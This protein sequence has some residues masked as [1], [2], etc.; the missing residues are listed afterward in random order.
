MA[1]GLTLVAVAMVS[2]PKVVVVEGSHPSARPRPVVRPP[3]SHQLSFDA[4][5]GGSPNQGV[6]PKQKTHRRDTVG[7]ALLP[8]T[9]WRR[10]E[11]RSYLQAPCPCPRNWGPQEELWGPHLGTSEWYTGNMDPPV[12]VPTVGLTNRHTTLIK[13]RQSG[14][15]RRPQPWIVAEQR[16]ALGRYQGFRDKSLNSDPLHHN[17][18]LLPGQVSLRP[19]LDPTNV[20]RAGKLATQTRPPLQRH[21]PAL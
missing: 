7:V 21:D 4:S 8:P 2:D 10:P 19:T 5:G 17:F 1:V 14:Q 6:D 12:G 16:N 9:S 11:R 3:Q 20:A 15:H 13:G 18:Q